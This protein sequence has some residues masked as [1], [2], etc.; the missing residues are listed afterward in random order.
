MSKE[1]RN[2]LAVVLLIAFI[3]VVVVMVTQG[4]HDTQSNLN[5][6]RP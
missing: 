4:Y 2:R 3:I 6:Y 5:Q 1:A